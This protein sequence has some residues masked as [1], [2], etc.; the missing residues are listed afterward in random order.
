M[1]PPR[2]SRLLSRMSAAPPPLTVLID[3]ASFLKSRRDLLELI[4]EYAPEM[5]DLPR[6]EDRHPIDLLQRFHQTFS[7]N[8]F[9]LDQAFLDYCQEVYYFNHEEIHQH[10]PVSEFARSIMVQ[11][12]GVIKSEGYPHD[13]WE[14]LDEALALILLLADPERMNWSGDRGMRVSWLESASEFVSRETLSLIPEPGYP[15]Q[16]LAGALAAAGHDDLAA[17]LRWLNSDTGN[18]LAD[19]GSVEEEFGGEYAD[20]WN[21]ETVESIREEWLE[22]EAILNLVE[23]AKERM[24]RQGLE[25]GLQELIRLAAGLCPEPGATTE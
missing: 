20:V 19:V 5:A 1:T 25:Q 10:D 15:P 14:Q 22:A 11:T 7:R 9:P 17:A 6:L 24:R 23:Q 18:L 2:L 16:E 12:Y 13:A 21:R 3:H 4:R 8:W